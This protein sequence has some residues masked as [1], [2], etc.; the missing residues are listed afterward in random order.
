MLKRLDL[1][2]YEA[3]T[4]QRCPVCRT[5][6]ALSIRG[7]ESVTCRHCAFV[8]DVIHLYAAAK[9]ID[10]ALAITELKYHAEVE[11]AD[12]LEESLYL[13]DAV[14]QAK[15]QRIWAQ[16]SHDFENVLSTTRTELVAQGCWFDFAV[17]KKAARYHGFLQLQLFDEFD[18]DLPKGAHEAKQWL[19]GYGAIA[20]PVYSAWKIVGFM[21][22]RT[23]RNDDTGLVPQEHYLPVID[24]LAPGVAYAHAVAIGTPE[25]FVAD[26]AVA[27]MRYNIRQ[28]FDGDLETPFLVPEQKC[29][30][31]LTCIGE[32]EPIFFTATL[33]PQWFYRATS[34]PAARTVLF[35]NFHELGYNALSPVGPRILGA[36]SSRTAIAT[37]RNRARPA[38]EAYARLLLGKKPTVAR[39]IF[40]SYP[41]SPVGQSRCCQAVS[42][43]DAAALGRIFERGSVSRVVDVD[44]RTVVERLEGWFCGSTLITDTTFQITEIAFEA[45]ETKARGSV[46]FRNIQIPFECPYDDIRRNT[47]SWLEH[48]IFQQP[49]QGLPVISAAWGTR[50]LRI[51]TGL[52]EP[53]RVVRGT[54]YGWGDDGRALFLPYF[55]IRPEGILG[56]ETAG[57]AGPRLPRPGP[58]TPDEWG[59]V[60]DPN[61]AQILLALLGNLIRTQAKLPGVGIAV[62]SAPHVVESVAAAL[63][64]EVQRDIRPDRLE[65]GA[66]SPV[67]APV[68][69]SDDALAEAFN[70]G[71]PMNVLMS[72][73]PGSHRLLKLH[74]NWLCLD[75]Q[76]YSWG[77]SIRFVFLMIRELL[78][79][80]GPDVIRLEAENI[81]ADIAKRLR[82]RLADRGISGDCF[83]TAAR[84]I[85]R[86]VN[87]AGNA[88]FTLLLTLHWAQE[89]G[90]LHPVIRD[91]FVVLQISEIR[92]ALANPL[93]P[94]TDLE[95]LAR[96]LL[97]VRYLAADKGGEWYI[98]KDAWESAASLYASK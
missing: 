87:H 16:A 37:L 86:S 96:Q 77:D 63:R 66:L 70:S 39:Q 5:E 30:V 57:T 46:R 75:V 28:I 38:H 26:S 12:G 42:G 84:D 55:V 92:A 31:D 18:F 9:R 81:Y 94:R 53:H 76:D 22:I 83:V 29:R 62:R 78:W 44:G 54:S 47:R 52:Q 48:I 49:G 80:P 82:L 27:A 65:R 74:R 59:I 88:A 14:E 67:P 3:A 58:L 13:S 4:E 97:S 23:H 25:V 36:Q 15:L 10:L 19:R 90:I 60:Q 6:S 64:L 93:T 41:L 72:V 56:T 50:L 79:T 24:G 61:A 71:S 33:E 8:G 95:M 21:L 68:T 11:F 35:P 91:G 73:D 45:G 69:W 43:D 1:S 20:I 17:T 7:S 98:I 89:R 32:S 2:G 34:V 85:S 40:A 51:A